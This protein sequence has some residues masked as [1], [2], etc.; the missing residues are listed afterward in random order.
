MLRE[1]GHRVFEFR[2]T[3]DPALDL[4][5]DRTPGALTTSSVSMRSGMSGAI[6]SASNCA[7]DELRIGPDSV[8]MIRVV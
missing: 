6:Q 3:G 5:Q 8:A 1:R 2:M 7:P 4:L